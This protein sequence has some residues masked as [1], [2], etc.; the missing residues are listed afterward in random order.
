MKR[1]EEGQ[2]ERKGVLKK[3]DVEASSRRGDRAE[4]PRASDRRGQMQDRERKVSSRGVGAEA[5]VPSRNPQHSVLGC[6]SVWLFQNDDE[7]LG[8]IGDLGLGALIVRA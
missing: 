1:C 6:W 4:Q 5:Q 8:Q 2:K 7:S 3:E